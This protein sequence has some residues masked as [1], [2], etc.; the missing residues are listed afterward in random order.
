MDVLQ[1]LPMN[2]RWQDIIDI[3]VVSYFIFRLYVLFR[4]TYVF[5][6]ILGI[7]FLWIFQRIAAYL[8]LI[9]TT[10]AMQGV[11]AFTAIIIIIVFRNEIK[12][13][14]Q[15][16][17]IGSI[18]W[19][20]SHKAYQTSVDIIT[21][22]V[23]ELANR[24]IGALLV[25]PAKDDLQEVVQSGIQW[26]GL[27][28]KE[29]LLSI[30]WPDN[31]AHDGAAIISGNKV[32]EVGAIL[33]LSRRTDLP[34]SYGT[35]HRA[36]LG[37]SE[38][39]DALV[40]VVSEETGH[41][42]AVKGGEIKP[43]GTN[44]EMEKILQ[45]HT[46]IAVAEKGVKEKEQLQLSLVALMIFIFVSG[47]WFSFSRGLET[48]TSMEVPIEYMNRNPGMELLESSI[49]SVNLS[50]SG[51]GPLIKSVKPD[52]V[53]VRIDLAK[54]VIGLN[55][56][57]VTPENITLP[58]GVTLKKVE[59]NVIDVT[60]DVPVKKEIPI[61]VDWTGKLPSQLIMESITLDPKRITVVG[62][63]K[64]LERIATVYT[65]KVALDNLQASGQMVIKLALTPASLKVENGTRDK[66]T[67]SYTIRTREP[68]DG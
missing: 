37:L 32:L 27:L 55:S 38:N 51:A 16:K 64:I 61:Q 31:P 29:M 22:S 25:I 24:K 63:S 21:Q 65:E 58:P 8:G 13:V 41:V 10:W 4:G 19:G 5:R 3:L 43:I 17:D 42:I 12:N 18:L 35:R 20:V 68:Q 6:V 50:L 52:Q 2:F 44:I 45:G 1:V 67:V 15:T 46:G 66:V 49:N 11:I 47:I 56:F 9:V 48:L 30:F 28:S 53:K 62:G 57:T 14:L 7:G 26:R 23:Y 36:A 54:A 60:L 39:T 40:I 33:P 34:S 59:P